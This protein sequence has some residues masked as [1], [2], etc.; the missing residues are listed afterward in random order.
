MIGVENQLDPIEDVIADAKLANFILVDDEDRERGRSLVMGEHCTPEAIN[1]AKYSRG[2]F[3]LRLRR[4]F[5][6]IGSILNGTSQ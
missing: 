6:K 3:A 1:Y 5:R 2:L 4:T